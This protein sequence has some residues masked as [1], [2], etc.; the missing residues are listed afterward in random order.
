MDYK[1]EILDL[2]KRFD[3]LE[4]SLYE[5]TNAIDEFL[6]GIMYDSEVQ[7][8]VRISA[9]SAYKNFFPDPQKP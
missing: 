6:S 4:K 2:Q 5:T 9:Q 7:E 3:E 8:N 1:E